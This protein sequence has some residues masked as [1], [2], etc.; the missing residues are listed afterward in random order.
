MG[1]D[2]TL[3]PNQSFDL[4]QQPKS[5]PYQST[6]SRA[7]HIL[8]QVT[9]WLKLEK[10][11][12]AHKKTTRNAAD[13][14]A[15]SDGKQAASDSGFDT[16]RKP[17]STDSRSRRGDSVSSG[18]S[19]ALDELD[20]ILS[21]YVNTE[22][23]T[24]QTLSQ[25]KGSYSSR[26]KSLRQKSRDLGR[27]SSTLVSSDT[28]HPDNELLVPSAEVVLD[29]TKTLT[30]SG[31]LSTSSLDLTNTSRGIARERQAWK[32][33]KTDILTLTHTLKIFGWRR[34]PMERGDD[35]DVER[36]C[37][38]L[39]NAVYVVSPPKDLPETSSIAHNGT[40]PPVPKKQ[41]P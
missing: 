32:Q 1:S 7:D 2:T 37:S 39:T 38:A 18:G 36:L 8:S 11:K 25:R 5:H 14:G 15:E 26:R 19:I 17:Q 40:M 35:V 21:K 28:D 13:G 31:G 24:N 12:R 10:S 34:V 29:N 27:R 41:P 3:E 22:S 4:A 16:K 9:E 30:W 23:G 20:H 33:F 6:L